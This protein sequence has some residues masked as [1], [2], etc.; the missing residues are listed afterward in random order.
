M[1]TTI[2]TIATATFDAWLT[3]LRGLP[4]TLQICVTALPVT[5]FALL[6]FRYA[7]SQSGIRAAKDRIKGYL[8]ELWLYKDH[9]AVLLRA[10]G[11]VVV[12][13]L[14]YLGYAL[15]PLAVMI[16]PLTLVVIQVE[17]HFA[18][19]ALAPG[20][21]A[22]VTA[23]MADPGPVSALDAELTAPQGLT[24]ETP[25]LRLDDRREVLWRI[26]AD[27]PGVHTL[28]VR[29]GAARA[30]RTVVAGLRETALAPVTY[31]ENDWRSLGYP[32][33]A[34]LAADA[35]LAAIEVSYPQAVTAF[36]GL[37]SASWVLL[38]ASMV[39]GYSLRGLFGVTF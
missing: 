35:V 19:R 38:G 13:S 25:P 7:S 8:L 21:S 9:P 28:T 6:V 39:L 24:V 29:V 27:A 31:R 32:G 4:A 30:S 5:I 10:Q 20:E 18:W 33:G 1:W 37:S 23:T 11:Q 2:D 12:G 36:L 3:P 17:S 22:I 26:R 16:V 34:P 14:E 15:V